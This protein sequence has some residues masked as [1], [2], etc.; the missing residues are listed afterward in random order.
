MSEENAL[1]GIKKRQQI[2]N[3][4]KQVFTWVALAAALG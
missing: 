1:T 2:T 4:R 3:T